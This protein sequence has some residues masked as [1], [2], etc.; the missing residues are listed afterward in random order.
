MTERAFQILVLGVGNLLLGDE[1]L[2]IHV[3][4]R[5]ARHRPQPKVIEVF[6]AGTSLFDFVGL[7]PQYSSL[8]LVDAIACGNAPGTIYCFNSI[9]EFRH[10]R[11]PVSLHEWSIV[12]SIRSA[13]ILNM[14]PKRLMIIG[15]EPKTIAASMNLSPQLARA[16]RRIATF[17]LQLQ[18][19]T[20]KLNCLGGGER[21]RRGSKYWTTSQPG[22]GSKNVALPIRH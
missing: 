22:T 12:E 13:E 4:R 17:I 19:P 11:A 18:A 5:I 16:S 14:S 21:P 9:E 1:G 10:A 3:V 2:G 8:V 7:F 6:E 15:A 20:S